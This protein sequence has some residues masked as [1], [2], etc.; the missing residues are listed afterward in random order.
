MKDIEHA[1]MMLDLAMRDFKALGGM[2]DTA[3]FDDGVFGFHAQ[4]A[5]EKSIKAWLAIL[6]AQYPK[7]HDLRLLLNLLQGQGVDVA[8][9][10]GLVEYNIYAVQF[11]YDSCQGGDEPIDREKAIET[12]SNLMSRV[13]KL[14]DRK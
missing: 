13:N 4:Q 2:A 7:T 3:V 9:F 12:V 10:F 11:R 8:P 6:G 1:R 14:V 5:V